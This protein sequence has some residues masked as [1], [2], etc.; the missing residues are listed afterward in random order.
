[1][2]DSKQKSSVEQVEKLIDLA[3]SADQPAHAMQY[4][5]AALNAAN[6]VVALKTNGLLDK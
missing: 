6:A 5:Q 1:M 2:T 4:A 3:A